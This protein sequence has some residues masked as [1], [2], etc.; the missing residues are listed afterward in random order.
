MKI[1]TGFDANV[2]DGEIPWRN[3][4]AS[5]NGLNDE[6][7]WRSPCTARLN[8]LARKLSPPYMA[9]ISPVRGRIATRA[10][11][12]PFG[13]VRTDWIA[14]LASRWSRRSSVVWTFKPPP[15]TR[16]VPYFEISCCLT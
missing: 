1:D 4:V 15:N 6:P 7:A 3:A 16:R 12:G 13:S 8:W 2:V 14:F 10:A 9:T 5:T 11:D